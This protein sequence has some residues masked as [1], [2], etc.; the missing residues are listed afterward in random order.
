MKTFS[1]MEKISHG[2]D[3]NVETVFAEG[4][5]YLLNGNVFE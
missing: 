5:A 1:V 2:F 4:N 3:G